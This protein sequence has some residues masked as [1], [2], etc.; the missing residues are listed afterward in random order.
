MPG[1]GQ[2]FDRHFITGALDNFSDE[3]LPVFISDDKWFTRKIEHLGKGPYHIIENRLYHPQWFQ[4]EFM[5]HLYNKWPEFGLEDSLHQWFDRKKWPEDFEG[6]WE[7]DYYTESITKRF[8]TAK[9]SLAVGLG[10]RSVKLASLGNISLDDVFGQYTRWPILNDWH[11]VTISKLNDSD[12]LWTNA[13]GVQWP[14]LKQNGMLLSDPNSAYGEHELLFKVVNGGVKGISFDGE[15]YEKLLNTFPPALAPTINHPVSVGSI[16]LD[17]VFGQYTRWPILNDWHIVT[18][19]KLND[20]D[21][22]WT[23]AAGVQWPLLKQNEMLLSDPNSA[24]G[25]Y[26]LLFKVVDGGVKGIYFDGEFY[27]KKIITMPPVPTPTSKKHAKNKK[28]T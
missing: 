26:E 1:D 19:S 27:E 24:Y 21:L 9:P 6:M 12:L 7:P 4:H 28:V 23:N 20:S 17:D 16:S 10:V 22:L 8:L 3:D 18:I 2:G 25:E 11:I 15:F 14:L 13:A 5:H